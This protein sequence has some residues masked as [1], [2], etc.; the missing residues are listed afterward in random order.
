MQTIRL[1]RPRPVKKLLKSRVSL[2]SLKGTT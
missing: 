1:D 2:L